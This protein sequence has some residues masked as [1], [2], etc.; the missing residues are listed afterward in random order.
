MTL[1]Q[2]VKQAKAAMEK[3][4]EF[5]TAEFRGVRSGRAS[6]ALVDS[7]RVDVES[8]G[9]QMGL[10]EL[11]S[12]TIADGN[13]IVIK[14]FDGGTLR[15]IAKA[16]EKSNIGINPQNDGKVVRL[17]VP[18]LSTE[19]R[20]Q[21]VTQIKQMAEQQKI[22]VRNVRRDTNKTLDGMKN[23]PLTED[24]IKRGQDDIQKLTD[25]HIKKIDQLVEE[26]S[27]EIMEV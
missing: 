9:S 1:D 4:R 7:I 14:P 20:N 6:T 25:E 2:I 11:A 26:K 10:K 22:A 17:P 8:Y 5:L 24:E 18:P 23:K 13:T 12:V 16:I 21:L 27:K 15:D 3:C 19:R